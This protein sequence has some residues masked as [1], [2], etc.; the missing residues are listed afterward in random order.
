MNYNDFNKISNYTVYINNMLWLFTFNETKII[1]SNE[2]HYKISGNTLFIININDYNTYY[3]AYLYTIDYINNLYLC[4]KCELFDETF[5][6]VCKLKS[7]I[8]LLKKP[9]LDSDCPICYDKLTPRNIVI[10]DDERHKVCEDCFLKIKEQKCPICRNK[11][12]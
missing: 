4:N 1:V 12:D 7:E 2:L 3:D 8:D 6:K 5:C 9:S 10:C 11:K